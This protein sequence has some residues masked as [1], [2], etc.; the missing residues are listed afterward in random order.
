MS[1][2]KAL[3]TMLA[4]VSIAKLLAAKKKKSQ[5]IAGSK[6]DTEAFEAARQKELQSFCR[7]QQVHRG[8]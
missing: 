5:D 2:K 8:R 6:V 3:V 7:Y 4:M 1:K